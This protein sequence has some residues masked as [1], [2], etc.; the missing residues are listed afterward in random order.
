MYYYFYRLSRFICTEGFI[1]MA[2]ILVLPMFALPDNDYQRPIDTTK[3]G[4]EN[5][6]HLLIEAVREND[7]EQVNSLLKDKTN[8]DAKDEFGKTALLLA[9][10]LGLTDI[11]AMLIESGANLEA[12]DSGGNTPLI[13]A[14]YGGHVKLVELLI[15]SGA[16]VNAESNNGSTARSW[17]YKAGRPDGVNEKIRQ[18]ID[19]QIEK[20]MQ[21]KSVE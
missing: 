16:K 1:F 6:Q 14:S 8:V 13:N 19:E 5:N 17:S 21:E 9:S 7:R 20:D 10:T 12:R 4:K 15:K 3:T 18:L 11:A 2:I